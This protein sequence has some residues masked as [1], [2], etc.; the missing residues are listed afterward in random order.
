MSTTF[1]YDRLTINCEKI[2]LVE[3]KLKLGL[4]LFCAVISAI[5]AIILLE[6]QYLL[7]IKIQDYLT[8]ITTKHYIRYHN[9]HTMASYLGQICV[10]V[11]SPTSSW[12]VIIFEQYLMAH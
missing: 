2:L 10:T 8:N 11:V 5:L 12:S 3:A 6:S 9:F 4:A 1:L 7:L